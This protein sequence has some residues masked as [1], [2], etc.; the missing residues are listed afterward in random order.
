MGDIKTRIPKNRIN[1]L[2]FILYSFIGILMFFIPI[3]LGGE[4][5]IPIDHIVNAIKSIPYYNYT[6]GGIIIITGG[7]YPFIF[8]TWNKDKVTTIFSILNVFGIILTFML[9]FN[10][11]SSIFLEPDMT[12]FIY[13]K[14][15][16]PVTTIIPVGSMFLA[17]I[18]DYGLMEFI[19]ILMGPIMKPIW[20]VPG[21][22]AIEGVAA[23]VGSYSIALLITNRAY[24]EGKY[25][26][27]EACIIATG[28]STVAV[29]IMMIV[30]KTSG[31]IEYWTFYIL[32]TLAT[33]FAVTAITA[34][35]YPLSRKPDTYYND[36]PRD[37]EPEL[38]GNRLKIAWQEAMIVADNSPSIFENIL[39]NLKDGIKLAISVAPSV[40][41][42]GV[43]GLVIANFTPFFD[44]L[45]Y[46]FY[47]FT[48]ILRLPD[49]L[50]AAKASAISISEMLLPAIIVAES[51]FI[52][53]FIISVVSVSEILF[54]AA[55]I[56]CIL[57]TEIP[58]TL[59]DI[60]I[61]WIERVILSLLIAAPILH[62]IF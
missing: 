12:P 26:E 53:R 31:I 22:S 2:K 8:K 25:T 45:G 7:I 38:R 6:Y 4:K 44:I 21:R 39:R 32:F 20:K 19:G 35:I 14:I 55:S 46:L 61:I 1:V 27:K 58:L 13:E 49:P 17:F 47:P 48:L 5:I 56:P 52:T 29:T 11:G 54:F 16:I 62:L 50:L 42:I 34:R 41:S 24:T 3:K 28:F 59:K 23:F 37:M 51:P 60:I 36:K 33:T 15:V 10:I 30:A 57:L 9:I 40:V 43:L 18:M